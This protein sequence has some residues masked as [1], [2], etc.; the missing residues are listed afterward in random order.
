[1]MKKTK[2]G[3][4]AVRIGRK[5]GVY[6]TWADCLKQVHK[7]PGAV[8][9]K[10][11]SEEAAQAFLQAEVS[12]T[13]HFPEPDQG[14]NTEGKEKE[15]LPEL[16]PNA[17]IAYVDGS[18]NSKTRVFGYGIV[19]FTKEGKELFFGTAQGDASS[20]RNVAGEIAGAMEAMRIAKSKNL[21]D[22]TIC[23]DYAGVRH[24][25]L[26]EWKANLPLTRQYRDFAQE[27]QKTITLHF[28]KIAAHTG[29]RYNEEADRLA[30]KG[31]GLL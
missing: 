6:R 23:Y 17:M 4:Y 29:D 31:A 11:D 7:F 20:H 19:C 16:A 25:A 10:L 24:W 28:V 8:Y 5:P 22:L 2:P 3:F 12:E 9:K 13:P 15:S 30:K 1:M 27:M 26:R 14:E 18:F 21:T